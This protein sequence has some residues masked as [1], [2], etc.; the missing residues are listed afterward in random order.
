MALCLQGLEGL[1]LGL[2]GRESKRTGRLKLRTTAARCLPSTSPVL[3]STPTSEI[4][5]ESTNRTSG[6]CEAGKL[7]TDVSGPTTSNGLT[8]SPGGS[9]ARTSPTLASGQE[10]KATEADSGAKCSASFANYDPA[11]LSWRTSQLCLDGGWAEFSETWPRAGMTR[12]GI[13]YQR[14]PLVPPISA[15]GFG[16]LPTPDK[17]LGSLR[18][19]LTGAM[20]ALTCYRK[21]MSGRRP[22]GANIG[23]S[24]RWCP[25]YIRE[26]LRTGGLINS[27][28]LE[29][30]MGFPDNWSMPEMTP[31]AK[32]LSRK[33]RNGSP[34]GSSRASE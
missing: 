2:N 4:A 9:P 22:S 5:A 28:W 14:P 27:V 20:D 23:S 34:K 25:E 10:S 30:L 24:L 18:G 32:P 31:S 17:S 29:R 15:T 11:T 7:G 8:S 6:E 1:T 12:N 21:E 19:G 33:S 16:Y 3:G 13:A 26:W